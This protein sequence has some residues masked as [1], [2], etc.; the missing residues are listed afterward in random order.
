MESNESDIEILEN[1]LKNLQQIECNYH[2]KM[3]EKRCKMMCVETIMEI[4][5][6]PIGRSES[7]EGNGNESGSGNDDSDANT[8]NKNETE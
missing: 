2:S 6:L 5:M 8:E 3:L 1:E 4:G 7:F